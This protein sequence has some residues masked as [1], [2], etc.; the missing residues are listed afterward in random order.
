YGMALRY[1]C[2]LSNEADIIDKAIAN[3]LARGLR[4]GDIM[5]PNMRKVGTSEMGSAI[6]EEVEKLLAS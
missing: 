5:Q 4:T 3:T 6:L 1:S 2:G